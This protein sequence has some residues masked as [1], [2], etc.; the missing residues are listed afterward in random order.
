MT[1]GDSLDHTQDQGSALAAMKMNTSGGQ[2]PSGG[3]PVSG[4]SARAFSGA[5]SAWPQYCLSLG[6]VAPSRT[7]PER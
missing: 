3:D 2:S 7:T 5:P 4:G 1:V 6:A